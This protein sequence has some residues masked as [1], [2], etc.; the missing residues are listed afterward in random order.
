MTTTLTVLLHEQRLKLY[1]YV[2]TKN[3][4]FKNYLILPTRN[5]PWTN[6]HQVMSHTLKLQRVANVLFELTM[7]LSAGKPLKA[8]KP[9]TTANCLYAEQHANN[10]YHGWGTVYANQVFTRIDRLPYKL[11]KNVLPVGLLNQLATTVTKKLIIQRSIFN[12]P[13]ISID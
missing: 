11:N 4:P 7:P 1:V 2:I 5:S 9:L 12:F 8:C 3:N 13:F 6:K 10:I